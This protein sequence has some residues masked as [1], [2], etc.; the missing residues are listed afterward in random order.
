MGIF[1]R[2]INPKALIS[3]KTVSV[4]D[5]I[6]GIRITKIESDRVTLEWKGKVKEIKVKDGGF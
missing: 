1:Y 4:G 3:G 5:D 6:D 2:E